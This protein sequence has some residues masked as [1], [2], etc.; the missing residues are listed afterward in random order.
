MVQLKTNEILKPCMQGSRDSL[1]VNLLHQA[2]DHTTDSL[3]HQV[4]VASCAWFNA[5]GCDMLIAFG[6]VSVDCSLVFF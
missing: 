1:Q 2:C 4:Q 6:F 5:R 3:E